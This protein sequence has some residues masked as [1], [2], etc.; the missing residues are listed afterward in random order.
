M[1]YTKI[2]YSIA[3]VGLFVFTLIIPD[4]SRAEQAQ[5]AELSEARDYLV[6][7]A[8]TNFRTIANNSGIVVLDEYKMDGLDVTV[9][10]IRYTGDIEAAFAKSPDIIYD[11]YD[12]A[13]IKLITN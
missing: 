9:T 1:P 6:M 3:V 8:P 5:L 10:H 7:D 11:V 12:D 2:I 4:H 13:G